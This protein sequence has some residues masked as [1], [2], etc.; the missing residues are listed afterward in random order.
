MVAPLVALSRAERATANARTELANQR[1]ASSHDCNLQ[2]HIF[3]NTSIRER[4]GM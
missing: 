2:K 4:D 3:L 1:Q